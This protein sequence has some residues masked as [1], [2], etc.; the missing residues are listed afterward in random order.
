MS[1]VKSG[2][3]LR[4][5][6][7]DGVFVENG[8]LEKMMNHSYHLATLALNHICWA[9]WFFCAVLCQANID[10]PKQ[11]RISVLFKM[12]K[13]ETTPFYYVLFKLLCLSRLGI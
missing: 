8:A 6:S 7:Y 1:A 9:A 13:N 10:H 11:A 12:L 5:T 2:P 3:S 4:V